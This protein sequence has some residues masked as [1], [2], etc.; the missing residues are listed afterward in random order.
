MTPIELNQ[1]I[2]DY[3]RQIYR[4]EFIGDIKVDKLD[5]EGYKVSFYLNRTEN[6]LIIMSDLEGDDF[7]KFIQKELRIRRLNG[8]KYFKATKLYQEQ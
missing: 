3:M 5:P 7:L 8:T 2:R 4:A 6:P 1:A